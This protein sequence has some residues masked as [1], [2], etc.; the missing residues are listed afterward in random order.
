M[1][2]WQG[3]N[4]Y[5]LVVSRAFRA[6]LNLRAWLPFLAYALAQG[7]VMILLYL[8]VRPP[9]NALFAA[10]PKS[11]VPPAFFSYPTHLLMIP[12]LLYNRAMI[13][14]GLLLESLLTAA[15]TWVFVRY[16]RRQPL[17]GLGRALA[18]VRFGYLQFMCFW[19]A[20]FVLLQGSTW[21]F[22]LAFG[23]LW[24]GFARRRALLELVHLG[25]GAFFNSL[26]AYATIV[27][28]V[29]KT[30]LGATWTRSLAVFRR[31]WLATIFTVL[32]GTLLTVPLGR[33]LETSPDWIGRFHP[34]VVLVVTGLTLLCGALVSFLV[35]AILTFWYLMQHA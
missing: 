27:I 11:L 24:V 5:L 4:Q 33:L 21:L 17:P 6:M 25:V 8:G 32:L 7:L 9:L 13:P 26:L 30:A 10:M 23:D 34:E 20:S 22:N 19:L 29:E 16:A 35:T 31:H 2:P 12:A 3:T 1:N 14:L 18:E 28:V 15:G